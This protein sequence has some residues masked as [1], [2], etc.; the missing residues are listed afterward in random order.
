MTWL[1]D[2]DETGRWKAYGMYADARAQLDEPVLP[3][4][5]WL[6]LEQTLAE[7]SEAL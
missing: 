5:Q 7:D 3:F 4:D 2:L 6:E 1:D